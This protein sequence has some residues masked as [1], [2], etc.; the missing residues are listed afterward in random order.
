[1]AKQGQHK[2]DAHDPS[3]SKGNNNPDKS[4]TITTGSVKKQETY[5]EQAREGKDTDKQAQAQKNDWN[6]DTRDPRRIDNPTRAR[7]GDLD[8]GRNG[9][10]SNANK[11][12]KQ[13]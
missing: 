1:M 10:D 8:S 3:K 7:Q 2:N 12:R 13:D 4:M 9:S 5:A 6:E 11:H